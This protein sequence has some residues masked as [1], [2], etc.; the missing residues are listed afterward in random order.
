MVRQQ[1]LNDGKCNKA[2]TCDIVILHQNDFYRELSEEE[3]QLANHGDF[4]FD[5]PS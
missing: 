3:R 4:N 2:T 5:H 1:L